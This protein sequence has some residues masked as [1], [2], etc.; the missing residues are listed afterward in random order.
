MTVAVRT[1]HVRG[2]AAFVKDLGR[3]TVMSSVA[4]RRLAS[5]REV[6]AAFE[7]LLETVEARAHATLIAESEGERVGFVMLIDDLPD[8]VTLLPQGFI[9][10]MAVEPS[11]RQ[12]GVGSAL[13]V[14][15]E[16]EVRRRGL[17]YMALMVTDENVA[18]RALYERAGYVTERRLMCKAL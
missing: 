18:A 5:E 2:D 14:A 8:E 9:A 12:Q 1:A 3:R 4:T 13:L 7:G 10:Y 11:C 16:D 17:P 15:A 6:Y